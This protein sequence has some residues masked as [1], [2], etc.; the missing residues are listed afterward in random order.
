ME[1]LGV[2]DRL[3]PRPSSSAGIQTL[4]VPA[5]FLHTTDDQIPDCPNSSSGSLSPGFRQPME[6][7][8]ACEYPWMPSKQT[9][10]CDP[11]P[12]RLKF[13]RKLGRRDMD[14]D[15]DNNWSPKPPQRSSSMIST[16]A[17][18]IGHHQ[19]HDSSWNVTIQ[20][21]ESPFFFIDDTCSDEE[22]MSA[23]NSRLS[24]RDSD[25]SRTT[26]ATSCFIPSLDS[27][28]TSNINPNMTNM[29]TDISFPAVEAAPFP[30]AEDYHDAEQGDDHEH[31]GDV[32]G[33]DMSD[34]FHTPEEEVA[35]AE[36]ENLA[37]PDRARNL[38]EA[39]E[40]A[41]AR[42]QRIVSM[43][44]TPL[45][46]P[47]K[48]DAV[49]GI[50]SVDASFRTADE[51]TTA[52]EIIKVSP[53]LSTIPIYGHTVP[54]PPCANGSFAAVGGR[55]TGSLERS[56]FYAQAYA[57]LRMID[58][59]LQSFWMKKYELGNNHG[60][61]A[62]AM[63]PP[64]L[65]TRV[66]RRPVHLARKPVA[67][68]EPDVMDL[69]SNNQSPVKEPLADDQTP[70]TTDAGVAPTASSPLGSDS[71]A[72]SNTDSSSA[73]ES[74]SGS[75]SFATPALSASSSSSSED[76]MPTEDCDKDMEDITAAEEEDEEEEERMETITPTSPES[77]PTQTPL[78]TASPPPSR[79][80][81]RAS[82]VRN[83]MSIPLSLPPFIKDATTGFKRT[84][85]S[86]S[87]ALGVPL[88]PSRSRVSTPTMMTTAPE[89]PPMS[90]ATTPRRK[91]VGVGKL[92]IGSPIPIQQQAEVGS[93][94][95]PSYFKYAGAAA[96]NNNS[97]MGLCAS[98]YQLD[99]VLSTASMPT[100]P[101]KGD[102]AAAAA[103][104]GGTS[105]AVDG[106][107]QKMRNLLLGGRTAN[108][109]VPSAHQEGSITT[110]ALGS[111]L[112]LPSFGG[113]GGGKNDAGPNSNRAS[114]GLGL[115]SPS[116]S[117]RFGS[118][119]SKRQSAVPS[120]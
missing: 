120:A 103:V 49:E 108:A 50:S 93:P 20:R 30:T 96:G 88:S 70:N 25:E 46:S 44:P 13:R 36:L 12:R 32:G 101:T 62:V 59:G 48:I 64:R 60:G 76:S 41:R 26:A 2:I 113:H 91:K 27:C 85:S 89:T 75:P 6:H 14:V 45:H 95:S 42:R 84:S 58:S 115:G 81:S 66:R 109:D 18:S 52:P 23:C 29:G 63:P 19:D 54:L 40:R 119:F 114:V 9:Y 86:P 80:S 90:G 4:G 73:D 112:R 21:P 37:N 87:P 97:G 61:N 39:R 43:M 10:S 69:D 99:A 56:R 71:D 15:I 53:S 31:V 1:S 111:G 51:S 98:P 74:V 67:S 57:E 38:N 5:F 16:T 17:A 55:R 33:E 117:S 118:A 106:K 94:G 83:F 11:S 77:T 7:L 104:G 82:Q 68:I 3:P 105:P 102:A 107:R 24:R 92:N 79:S 110:P 100:T 28:S 65:T 34:S 35:L 78:S 72:L 116:P 22:Y 47:T 8:D